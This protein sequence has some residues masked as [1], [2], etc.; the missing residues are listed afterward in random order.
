V[1]VKVKRK[2]GMLFVTVRQ[3]L[4]LLLYYVLLAVMVLLVLT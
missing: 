1:K 2:P 3:V 4:R